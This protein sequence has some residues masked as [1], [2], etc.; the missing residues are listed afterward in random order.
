MLDRR[1]WRLSI[2]RSPSGR[3]RRWVRRKD[4]IIPAPLYARLTIVALSIVLAVTLGWYGL[5]SLLHRNASL[6]APTVV[7]AGIS[8]LPS[9]VASWQN[10]AL[11]SIESGI[12][13]AQSGNIT[14]AEVATD[15]ASSIIEAARIASYRTPADFFETASRSL[16]RE[17]QAHPENTRLF[18]HVTTARVNL[19]QLRSAQMVSPARDEKQSNSSERGREDAAVEPQSQVDGGKEIKI[20]APRELAP[21]QLLNPA[22]LG[23]DTIDA[24]LMPETMEILLPPSSRLFVDNVRVQD[25]RIKGAAQTLDGIHWKNVTFIGTRLRYETGE[26]DLQKVHFVGCTF[27]IPMDQRGAR[28]ANAIALGQTSLTIVE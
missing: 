6:A 22:A 20:G 5:R 15:R 19:A 18:E 1:R 9:A 11:A 4:T 12:H 8:S 2:W 13:E 24:T 27:G 28:F 17:L 3:S 7:E 10:D 14:A 23:V 26:L 16:D 21:N 25:L